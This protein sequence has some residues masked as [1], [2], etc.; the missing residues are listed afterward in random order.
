MKVDRISEIIFSLI[1]TVLGLLVFV[2]ARGFPELPE[3][4]P[5][6]GLFPAFL[7]AGLFFCGIMLL[8]KSLKFQISPASG[9]EGKWILVI[10]ILAAMFI[11]PFFYRVVGFFIAIAIAILLV[12]LLMRLKI[13]SAILTALIT[14]GFIYVIFNQILHVPL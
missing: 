14:T 8:V 4:H 3:G 11:F 10:S 13:V 12:G 6:P 7:G 2:T 1:V 5:G 9:F